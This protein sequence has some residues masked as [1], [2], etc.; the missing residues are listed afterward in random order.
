MIQFSSVYSSYYV[1][2]HYSHVT[3]LHCNHTLMY[4]DLSLIT[5][6]RDSLH[7]DDFRLWLRISKEEEKNLQVIPKLALIRKCLNNEGNGTEQQ[8]I[9]IEIE[10]KGNELRNI[11]LMDWQEV[12]F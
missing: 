8:T 1:I 4:Q 6:S 2:R 5:S 3:T 7:V 12:P 10:R 9:V 11:Y